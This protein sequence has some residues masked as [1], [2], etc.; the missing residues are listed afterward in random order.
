MSWESCQCAN[1]YFDYLKTFYGILA[2]DLHKII[3]K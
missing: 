1:K 3:T 2:N